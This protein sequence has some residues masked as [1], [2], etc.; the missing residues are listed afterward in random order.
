MPNSEDLKTFQGKII[1]ID[2]PA[3]SGKSTTAK[4]LA[5]RLGFTYLDTGAMYRAVALAALRRKIPWSDGDV[6]AVLA[7]QV[8]IEFVPDATRGQLT[9]LDGEDVT[10]AIRSPEATAGSSAVAVH[11]GVRAEMVKRQKE[12][13]RHGNIVAEGRDTTSVVFPRADLKIYLAADI[14]TRAQRRYLEAVA[15]GDKTTVEEQIRLL[16]ARDKNDSERAVS[17]L[18][19]VPDAVLVDTTGLTIEG[20]VEKIFALAFRA[21]ASKP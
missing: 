12:L 6:V 16:E 8:V 19:R 3:G 1:A 11:P 7:A 21:F 14:K 13:G 5:Q 4:L 2:G 17:P 15:R 9:L 20:Q 18:T 10:E